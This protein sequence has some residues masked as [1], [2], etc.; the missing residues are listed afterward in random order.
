MLAVI[1]VGDTKT[2]D[3]L[4]QAFNIGYPDSTVIYTDSARLCIDYI[5]AKQ[6][7]IIVIDTLLKSGDGYET[8]K[9]IRRLSDAP[10]LMLSYIKEESQLVK[11]LELGVDD[12]VVKPVHSMEIIARIRTLI[13]RKTTNNTGRN[14][15]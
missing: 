5:K 2:K 7:D 13:R 8:V 14:E 6:P 12:Y 4:S 9:K 10:I 1:A 11:A 3:V 15:Y